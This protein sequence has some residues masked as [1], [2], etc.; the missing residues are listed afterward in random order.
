MDEAAEVVVKL[1]ARQQEIEA[2][3]ASDAILN[4]TLENCIFQWQAY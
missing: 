2:K 3:K 1:A 4:A